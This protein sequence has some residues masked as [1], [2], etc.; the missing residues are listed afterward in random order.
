MAEDPKERE[1]A[2][3]LADTGGDAACWANLVC[4]ECGAVRADEHRA[5]CSQRT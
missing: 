1:K 3:A 4:E 2:E 5:D